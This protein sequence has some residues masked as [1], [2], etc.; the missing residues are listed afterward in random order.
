[1]DEVLGLGI[2]VAINIRSSQ[3]KKFEMTDGRF[4]GRSY[5]CMERGS[6]IKRIKKVGRDQ[7]KL[8]IGYGMRWK[9]GAP[10]M[11]EITIPKEVTD[12]NH[13]RL[14]NILIPKGNQRGS[15]ACM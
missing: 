4:K 2:E 12:W 13:I 3:L 14:P 5:G 6:Q 15:V 7:W 8:E 1:M 11:G 10:E 9:V